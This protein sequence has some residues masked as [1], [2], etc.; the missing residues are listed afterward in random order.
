[1]DRD[2]LIEKIM[3]LTGC[4]VN[5]AA[6]IIELFK[7]TPNNVVV[8]RQYTHYKAPTRI[9]RTVRGEPQRIRKHPKKGRTYVARSGG[10]E[11][12]DP[13]PS[14]FLIRGSTKGKI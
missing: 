13:G 10:S 5:I 14:K 6:E 9:A 3:E 11:T 2:K 4:D 12:D 8:T 1:M 7:E